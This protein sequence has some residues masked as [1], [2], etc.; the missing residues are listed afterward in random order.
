MHLRV[1]LL[2]HVV[3]LVADLD[4]DR[5]LTVFRIHLFSYAFDETLAVLEF[6]AVVVTDDIRQS[7]LFCLCL[8]ARE[9]IETLI[10]FRR[11]RRLVGRHHTDKFR[12]QQTGVQHLSLGI[13]RVNA[14]ALDGNLGRRGVEVLVL[15]FAHV[16][17]IHRVG[18]F[19]S[20][21]LYVEMVGTHANLLIGIERHTYLTVL[22][23]LVGFQK[24]H[25]LH[26]LGYTSLVVGTQQGVSVR[27]NQVLARMLQQFGE[28]TW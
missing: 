8:H 6:L 15:Q 7:G 27:H 14:H 12:C 24:Y 20:E 10:A 13:S 28:L 5:S 2:L 1:N 3:I 26:N 21:F 17:T 25:G 23:V 18:P 11:L 16:A 9:V 19:A 4:A 22:D